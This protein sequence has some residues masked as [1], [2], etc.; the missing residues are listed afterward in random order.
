MAHLYDFHMEYTIQNTISQYL[1]AAA[2]IQQTSYSQ[3]LFSFAFRFAPV[4]LS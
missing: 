3:Y 1:H 4:L 2:F